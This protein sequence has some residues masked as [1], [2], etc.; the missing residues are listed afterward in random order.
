MN[1]PNVV[2]ENGPMGYTEIGPALEQS[3]VTWDDLKW[4]REAWG[5]KLI[6]KGVHIGDDARKASFARGFCCSGIAPSTTNASKA[7]KC[8]SDYTAYVK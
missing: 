4:I 6:I 5:G 7:T 3:V 1:F 2:L 8:S